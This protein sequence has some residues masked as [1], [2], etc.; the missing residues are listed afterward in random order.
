MGSGTKPKAGHNLATSQLNPA[1]STAVS[2]D[3]DCPP[4]ITSVRRRTPPRASDGFSASHAASPAPDTSARE[5]APGAVIRSDAAVL[6]HTR[7]VTAI[8]E[9]PETAISTTPANQSAST[10]A[11]ASVVVPGPSFGRPH[12]LSESYSPPLSFANIHDAAKV[13]KGAPLKDDYQGFHRSHPHKGNITPLGEPI[14][15]RFRKSSLLG[16][17]IHSNRK[18]LD[19][20][21]ASD[22][23]DSAALAAAQ[24]LAPAKH[25][26]RIPLIAVHHATLITDASRTASFS[27]D[28]SDRCSEK[29]SDPPS[30]N[31]SVSGPA[32][33]P[34]KI[35]DLNL[36]I[37]E[38]LSIVKHPAEAVSVKHSAWKAP[39]SWDVPEVGWKEQWDSDSSAL[40]DTDDAQRRSRHTE[41][42]V[43]VPE[44]KLATVFSIEKSAAHTKPAVRGPCH[45]IR[46][47]KE[48][49]TFTTMLCPVDITTA[50]LLVMIQKKLFLDTILNYQLTL[51]CG[52]HTK[53]LDLQEKPLKIQLG[54]LTVQGYT[55]KENLH[56]IG[57]GDMLLIYRFVIENISLRS[58]L[59]EEQSTSVNSYVDVHLSGL[60][61]KTIPIV[62]HQHTF[63][64]EK[65]DVSHNPAIYIPLDFI[66]SCSN[67]SAVNFLHN[68]CSRFPHNLLEALALLLHLDISSNFLADIPVRFAHLRNLRTLKLNLN[69][70][71]ALH[72]NFGKLANLTVLNLSLNY[73]ET[74]PECINSLTALQELDLS[75]NDL[76]AVSPNIGQLTRLTKLNLCSNKLRCALPLA[77]KRLSLLKWLDVRYN[78]ISNID[79]LG[80]LPN[81]EV[82]YASKN[83]ISQFSDKMKSLRLLKFDRNPV[84]NFEFEILLPMLTVLDLSKAKLSALPAEFI[85]KIPNI[86]SLMLAKNHIVT[87]PDE[88][89]TLKKL[90]RLS[91]FDNNI[92]TLPAS[93]GRLMS[94]QYLDLHLNNIETL[95]SEIWELG[96]LSFL[97]VSSNILRAFP[98]PAPRRYT[99]VLPLA[100]SLAALYVADNCLKED[101]FEAFALLTNVKYL[102][103]SYNDFVEI[104]EGALLPLVK[105]A[106]LH[107]SGNNLTKLP[108]EDFEHLTELQLLFTNN[109]KLLTIPPELSNCKRLRHFDVGLNQLRYNISNW[110]YDWNWCFNENLVYLNFSGNKRFEIK[111]S[112]SLTSEK[113]GSDGYDSLLVLKN[114]RVLGLMDVTL[115]TPNV[116][117]QSINIRICTTTSELKTVGY[118]V[119]DC[120][121]PLETVN[122]RDHFT[123]KFRGHE[124]E[125]LICS[126]NGYDTGDA[127]PRQ[128]TGHIILFIC[129]Q[130]FAG[131]FTAELARSEQDVQEA[132]RRAFLALNREV[133]SVF[134][135][136]RAGTYSAA[137]RENDIPELL[138]LDLQADMYKG[139]CMAV[140]YI[141]KAMVYTANLGDIE[142]LLLRSNS[143]YTVLST[144]HD[145]TLRAEFERIRS[146]GGYVTGDG[147]LDLML[148][149]LRGIGFFGYVPH[150]NGCPSTAEYDLSGT[151][152][153]LIVGLA[154]LWD[155]VLHDS[156]VDIVRQEQEDPT[157]AAEKLRDHALCYGANDRV[158][159]IVVTLGFLNAGLA[160][161]TVQP[162]KGRRDR[163]VPSGDTALRRL[164]D[165]INPPTGYIALVF[166]DIKN[167]TLL[168]DTYPV[169]MRSAIKLH[170]TIMRRQLRIVGG[171]EVKTEGDLFMVSFP[172]APLA[173]LWCFNVQ[174]QLLVEDWPQEILTMDE[175]CEVADAAGNVVFRGLSVRMGIHWGSPVCELDMVTR[176]MDYFGPMVNRASRI[177]SSADGGQIAISSDFLREM[178]RVSAVHAQISSGA[179][180]VE[181]AHENRDTYTVAENELNALNAMSCLYF[182]LGERK[183]KGLEAPETITLAFP[184]SLQARHHIFKKRELAEVIDSSYG[185]LPIECVLGLRAILQRLEKIC[186]VLNAG[187][188]ADAGYNVDDLFSRLPSDLFAKSLAT[189]VREK[190]LV[191]L[192]NHLVTRLENCV[193]NLK[194]RLAHDRMGGGEGRIDFTGQRPI[195][196]LMRDVYVAMSDVS[197][198]E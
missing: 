25:K 172:S 142:I 129:K 119:L 9:V 155:F 7:E 116:P 75:Y 14:K 12:I 2:T 45:I 3:A 167:S 109:N 101:A 178:E 68:G 123:Q 6:P 70:L 49:N 33:S 194:L 56:A 17:L 37:E 104:P 89:G 83:D 150:T 113:L 163:Q 193:V 43:K 20:G 4:P 138:Q 28:L 80:L 121:G 90:S 54:L 183:L 59:H 72:S 76:S 24:H 8:L 131:L 189:N 107:V 128:A 21:D 5:T 161:T 135:A 160:G 122:F 168:W 176:R 162:R 15:P 191:G 78:L 106:H 196:E 164:N 32:G 136:L 179:A 186:A 51:Y 137:T 143:D 82:L 118:G 34:S 177:E 57:R 61:L 50:D 187:Y 63:V 98:M 44:T 87:L 30:K 139:C 93:V 102:N 10:N 11:P 110:P 174:N 105:L 91:V 95:P 156:A 40:S 23:S 157:I 100:A 79:V 73:F 126:F 197:T 181:L 175:G 13:T 16:K 195:W 67:L 39:D 140:V 26:F 124:D 114:L 65:L 18:D 185:A 41:P 166:T 22:G 145:P 1:N 133:N 144:K 96:R 35:F 169:A 53:V 141:R 36:N 173:L 64:I 97:N 47:F 99:R 77:L 27:E 198:H 108:A 42:T 146:S 112:F 88:L 55:D 48:D 74:Y 148:L 103:A 170:N 132:L 159:V 127:P 19:A 154:K 29:L 152:G 149:V 60:G 92:Q 151:D 188:N 84:T 85:L 125:V 38:L 31:S 81:L 46:I 62:F 66:Q 130:L 153:V 71:H 120:M 117:D 180:T 52:L 171:Y 165:E 111:Q 94:L 182:V 147:A 158:S 115:T 69:Q 86:E 58:L 190:Y 192:L 184:A 134:A